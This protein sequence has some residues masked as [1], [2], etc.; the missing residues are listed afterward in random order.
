M[1]TTEDY[2]AI[3]GVSPKATDEDIRAA[4]KRMAMRYH[5][6]V[7]SGPDADERMRQLIAAYQTLR[8]P[9]QRRAYDQ[10]H[11]AAMK[12]VSGRSTAPDVEPVGA[13]E[14][15]FP[16]LEDAISGG[17][18]LRL[19]GARYALSGVAVA[20]LLREG[21]LRGRDRPGA[22]RDAWHCH[23]CGHDWF[24]RQT[25]IPA[26]CPLCHAR[27][28]HE[29]LL[30]RCSQCRAVFESAEVHEYQIHEVKGQLQLADHVCNPYELYPLC[31]HCRA[32][33]WCPAEEQRLAEL[34]KQQRLARRLAR[35]K[36]TLLLAAL[37]AATSATAYFLVT[38]IHH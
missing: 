1:T 3:L 21:M 23:R 5:P 15:V 6:D 30:L 31:P 26:T 19:Q 12:P 32:G 27:D 16:N 10:K 13:R 36:A 9:Q 18:T 33:G 17:M 29:Y 25:A 28:W 2:Y 4:F 7:Y 38:G 8:D 22:Q 20:Q 37:A 11:L 34:R 24:A 14:F 35:V